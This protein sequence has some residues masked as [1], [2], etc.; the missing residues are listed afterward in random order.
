MRRRSM[1]HD[2]ATWQLSAPMMPMLRHTKDA[3]PQAAGSTELAAILVTTGCIRI[4]LVVVLD[5]REPRRSVPASFQIA[6][7]QSAMLAED[8]LYFALFNVSGQVANVQ[9]GPHS[10]D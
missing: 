3:H 4:A 7:L 9:P 10:A 1:S 5:K 8:V 6:R 2:V